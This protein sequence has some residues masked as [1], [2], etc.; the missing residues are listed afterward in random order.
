MKK[1]AKLYQNTLNH[2]KRRKK[3]LFLTTSNRWIGEKELP[4]STLLAK[5]L[6]RELG[7]KVTLIDVPKL[8]IVPCE[9][10]VSTKNGNVCGIK[11]AILKNKTK[12]PTG[13]HRCWAS[14]NEP[15]DQLWKISKE[16][17]QSD[18]VVFFTSVRW[19]QTNV[20]YQKLIERL[21]W[22]E[23]RHSTLGEKN[24]LGKIH[25]GII[26]VGQNWRG[27]NVLEVQT[28]VL[29]YFGFNVQQNLCWNW[30]YL[31]NADEESNQSYIDGVKKFN[32]LFLE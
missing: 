17:L 26:I 8:H 19:G 23:N 13:H 29:D 27:K 3:I 21:T 6:Q 2:L 1:E 32:Q 12:N 18:C 30:Q 16:L 11:K 10:N 31:Q 15:K 20:I 14:I 5:R 4:K 25:A 22:L 7:K 24:I 28:K 9:G